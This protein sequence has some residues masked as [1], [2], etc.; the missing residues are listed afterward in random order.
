MDPNQQNP[1]MT[2]VATNSPLSEGNQNLP[3]KQP[4]NSDLQI[5]SQDGGNF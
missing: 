2:A 1:A 4:G 5:Q 3:S